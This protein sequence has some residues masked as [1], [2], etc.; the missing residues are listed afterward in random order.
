[1]S[2]YGETEDAYEA[3]R[4]RPRIVPPVVEAPISDDYDY[5]AYSASTRLPDLN[6]MIEERE[7]R[8]FE[9]QMAE[10]MLDGNPAENRGAYSHEEFA[11]YIQNQKDKAASAGEPFLQQQ[12][13]PCA[14]CELARVRDG[15]KGL[16]FGLNKLRAMASTLTGG[17]KR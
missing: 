11:L 8:L 7:K 5:F 4:R 6:K 10:L 15:I 3:S 12:T 9:L 2:N 14:D 16:V 17:A 1:M 13:C